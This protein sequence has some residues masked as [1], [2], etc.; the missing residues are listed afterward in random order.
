M[1]IY[2]I[3]L[4]GVPLFPELSEWFGRQGLRVVP[5]VSASSFT[6]GTVHS[7]LSGGVGSVSYYSGTSYH[8][9]VPEALWFETQGSRL[10][11][12]EAREQG[13]RVIARN[14]KAWQR[15]QVFR[16]R[17]YVEYDCCWSDTWTADIQTAWEGL[18]DPV[19]ADH[20][21][22]WLA[23]CYSSAA[24][25]ES[26]ADLQAD[27]GDALILTIFD[28]FHDVIFYTGNADDQR[29]R[30][31]DLLMAWLA[32]WQADEPDAVFWFFSDHGQDIG[33]ATR[34]GD[35]L[36]WAA[37]RDNRHGWPV[38]APCVYSGDFGD[39]VRAWMTGDRHTGCNI[40][41]RKFSEPVW[42]EDARASDDP[43]RVCTQSAI[44]VSQSPSGRIDIRQESRHLHGGQR[45]AWSAELDPGKLVVDPRQER[46]ASIRF[47]AT[48]SQPAATLGHT[49]ATV[50]RGVRALTDDGRPTD[51][52]AVQAS[53]PVDGVLELRIAGLLGEGEPEAANR[54]RRLEIEFQPPVESAALTVPGA[55]I[56]GSR[57][58]GDGLRFQILTEQPIPTVAPVSPAAGEQ[59]ERRFDSERGLLIQVRYQLRRPVSA[60]I[61]ELP[62]Y[63]NRHK[64][65][66]MG[67]PPAAPGRRRPARAIAGR[68]KR[69]L[70]RFLRP[71]PSPIASQPLS[72]CPARRPGLSAGEHEV[73]RRWQDLQ[74][75]TMQRLHS[76]LGAQ[77][78][79]YWLDAG[80]VLGLVR[81]SGF[82]P[83]DDDID[84]AMLDANLQALRARIQHDPDLGRSHGLR[85]NRARDPNYVGVEILDDQQSPPL[86]SIDIYSVQ[87]YACGP[88]VSRLKRRLHVLHFAAYAQGLEHLFPDCRNGP[89]RARD[90]LLGLKYLL[91][92][93]ALRTILGLFVRADGSS[94]NYHHRS[95]FAFRHSLRHSQAV[96]T[97]TCRFGGRELRAPAD[98]AAYCH[99]LFGAGYREHP[100]PERQRPEHWSIDELES[101]LQRYSALSL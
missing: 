68:L 93:A 86:S 71:V 55:R 26:I 16:H 87:R 64:D 41:N 36:T 47:R 88:L 31:L 66:L 81:H 52:L 83:W 45:W 75:E 7:M 18:G 29:Q 32:N 12:D 98:P 27:D 95:R 72:P 6:K 48:A 82:I 78:L 44:S 84:L 63:D 28:A 39:S 92:G 65:G 14:S 73:L 57:S 91:L 58:G 19:V 2:C 5:H 35:Y 96:P 99:A 11:W 30:A 94:I 53:T 89:L 90:C 46:Q 13:F 62:R 43:H 100:P 25:R 20:Y 38:D 101:R 74:L 10:V 34:P 70:H 33:T 79:D 54:L 17:P 60:A 69:R 61:E 40:Y 4:D 80:S 15:E 59:F 1:K 50:L 22:D 21:I 42:H 23:G 37:I 77:E 9:N 8:D 67:A 85:L 56:S 76:F 49:P 97:R 24:E 3:L 51:R